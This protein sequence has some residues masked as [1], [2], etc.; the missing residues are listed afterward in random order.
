VRDQSWQNEARRR[1]TEIKGSAN[2]LET[3]YALWVE[4]RAIFVC[5]YEDG[6]MSMVARIYDFSKWCVQ[7]SSAAMDLITPVAVC[8]YEHIP[9]NEKSLKDMP[10]WFS[11]DQVFSLREAF[12]HLVGN[13]GFYRIVGLYP[14]QD[15]FPGQAGRKN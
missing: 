8:F 5:A 14:E 15:I 10:R 3:P 13:E 9:T 6:D 1:F 4:M 12:S 11:L 7:H 2:W